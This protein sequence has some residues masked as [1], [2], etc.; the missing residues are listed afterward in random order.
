MTKYLR[1]F[2]SF[3]VHIIMA[4]VLVIVVAVPIA[5]FGLACIASGLNPEMSLI[6]V[7][8]AMA[9]FSH[10][11]HYGQAPQYKVS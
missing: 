1:A 8:V 5:L 7:M 4:V 11:R 6:V 10:A 2:P 9:F 3:L